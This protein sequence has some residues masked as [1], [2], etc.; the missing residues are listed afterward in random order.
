MIKLEL[1]RNTVDILFNAYFNDTLSHGFCTSC[2]VGNII[3]ANLN[4]KF[5]E[6]DTI[7]MDKEPGF[8]LR[9][10]DWKTGEGK[11]ISFMEPSWYYLINSIGSDYGL[12][13]PEGENQIISTGYNPGQLR[14]IESA[15][16]SA[17]KGKSD[18]DWMFN[19]LVA[20]LDA[21]KEI[22]QVS[23]EEAFESAKPFRDHYDSLIRG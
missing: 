7:P 10:F 13:D 17:P 21:L 15:F 23:E 3:A 4:Y 14:Q 5:E 1:Y 22:H 20:V 18:E 12:I 6:V 8:T 11:I 16:E 2:A 9:P 19:G